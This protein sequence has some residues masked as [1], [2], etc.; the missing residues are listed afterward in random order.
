MKIV[1]LDFD[2]VLNSEAFFRS[3]RNQYTRD[4]DRDAVARLTRIVTE[5]G[6]KVVVSS[7]WRIDTSINELRAILERH[8]FS[9]EV[10]DV[11][12]T[13]VHDAGDH[14]SSSSE[15]WRQIDTWLV[16]HAGE[17]S[18]YIILDDLTDMGPHAGRHVVTSLEAGLH[19]D[20]VAHALRMLRDGPSIPR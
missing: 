5:S 9:G 7:T 8:G 16:A 6:A 20:H 2:G 12:P 17:W 15:R 4:L 14:V 13:S 11:T 1:F 18:S 3:N 19:D 10:L